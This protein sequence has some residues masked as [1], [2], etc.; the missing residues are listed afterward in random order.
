MRK[1]ALHDDP[2]PTPPA[3]PAIDDC[4]RSGCDRCVFD[5][6]QDA[7]E[8]YRGALGAWDARQARPR[9]RAKPRL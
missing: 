6:Y 8:R 7:L 5:L 9:R 2:P 3:R 4:C 1:P